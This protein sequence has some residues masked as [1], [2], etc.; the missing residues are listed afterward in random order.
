MLLLIFFSDTITEKL[1]KTFAI[2]RSTFQSR[3]NKAGLICLSIRPFVHK[4]FL[5]FQWHVGRG[6]W[7]MHAGMQYDPIQG[8]G[9]EPLKVGN[10]SI[11]NS[12]LLHH[13]Q[14]ELAN[15]Y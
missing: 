13:L 6:Q 1:G 14:W 4:K 9:H 11:F 2:F 8:Q 3:P 15:D 10:S 5:R 12:F 7:V